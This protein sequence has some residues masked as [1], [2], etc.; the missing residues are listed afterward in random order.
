MSE[1]VFVVLH[2]SKIWKGL[3]FKSAERA[4]NAI[5]MGMPKRKWKHPNENT[6]ICSLYGSTFRIE[7]INHE[8]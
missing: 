3:Y 1:P 7:E 6:F 5:R 8:F 4:R 2:G